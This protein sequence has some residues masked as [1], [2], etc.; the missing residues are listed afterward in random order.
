MPEVVKVTKTRFKSHFHDI[1]VE[2]AHDEEILVQMD[3]VELMTEFLSVFKKQTIE[4]DYIPNVDKVLK[5]ALDTVTVDEI[6][7]RVTQYSG[8]ILDQ[9]QKCQMAHKNEEMMMDFF[10]QIIRDKNPDVKLKGAYNLPCFV[11]NYLNFKEG[12][13]EVFEDIYVD[14]LR[15][16]T[17]NKNEIKKIL[18]ASIHETMALIPYS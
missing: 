9:L 2:L 4:S 17:V 6:R 11:L 12:N 13:F 18:S 15:D 16:E 8:K 14:L 3:G 10:R 5:K 1:V 7:L